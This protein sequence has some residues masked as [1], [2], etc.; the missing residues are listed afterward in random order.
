MVKFGTLYFGGLSSVPLRGSIPLARGH[1]M[2][3]THIQ[4]RGRLA[5]MLTQGES[6]LNE[7]KSKTK[8]REYNENKNQ[9]KERG[10]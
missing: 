4:N 10:K 8:K 6:S 9:V 7:K 1:A 2:A 3:V 5:Q